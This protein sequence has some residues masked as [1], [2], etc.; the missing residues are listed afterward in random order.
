MQRVLDG[1][2]GVGLEVL[3]EGFERFGVDAV[4]AEYLLEGVLEGLLGV[5]TVAEVLERF[6]DRGLEVGPDLGELGRVEAR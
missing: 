1:V 2:P 6:L 5:L 3:E 4:V